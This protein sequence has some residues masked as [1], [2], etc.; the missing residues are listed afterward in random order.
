MEI[1]GTIRTPNGETSRITA[2]GT[3]Y[4]EARATLDTLIPEGAQLIAIRT[5]HP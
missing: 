1:T 2:S 3:T 5:D 4:D